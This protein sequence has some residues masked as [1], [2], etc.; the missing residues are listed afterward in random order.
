MPIRHLPLG[1]SKAHQ[2]HAYDLPR[3]LP[4]NAQFPFP[5]PR[6]C[7]HQSLLQILEPSTSMS[8]CQMLPLDLAL[9]EYFDIH[10][11]IFCFFLLHINPLPL[12][13]H[14]QPDFK[15]INLI[16]TKFL[17]LLLF[18]SAAGVLIQV[19]KTSHF[20]HWN[21]SRIKSTPSSPS[22]INTIWL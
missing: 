10:C 12:L 9:R 6:K 15:L 3:Y 14:I 11:P 18:L 13:P 17:S 21:P 16:A 19:F 5:D 1:I 8:V 20:D 7:H 22:Q 2:I 4:L